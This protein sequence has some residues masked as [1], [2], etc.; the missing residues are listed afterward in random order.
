MSV[1]G[2]PSSMITNARIRTLAAITILGLLAALGAAATPAN[3][4][5]PMTKACAK[6]GPCAVGDKGPGGGTVFYVA[7]SKKAWGRY[8]E[9][10]P[11]RWS[12]AVKDPR[13]PWCNI[14]DTFISGAAGTKVG[15]GKANTAAMVGA[16]TSGAANS[17]RAY[18]GGGKS[19]W[20][21][22]S[23]DELNA[24]YKKRLAI[25]GMSADNYWSS[26]DV[27]AGGAGTQY[28]PNGNWGNGNKSSALYVRPV[29]AF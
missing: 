11:V 1:Q 20:Y 25:G 14:A 24:I 9:A 19:D 23:K 21:L 29:R 4:R 28:F 18:K 12:G 27:D 8:L 2:L 22:P 26:T 16:C 17:S 13:I 7:S 6:G 5:A 3:A 15:T 10:A